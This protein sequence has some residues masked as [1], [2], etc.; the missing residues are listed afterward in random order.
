M[1]TKCAVGKLDGT[2]PLVRPIC[3]LCDDSGKMALKG[4]IHRT[5]NW[6]RL[7]Q[8]STCGGIL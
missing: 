8:G 6:L 5:V 7:S 2:R 4:V 1:H 3:N